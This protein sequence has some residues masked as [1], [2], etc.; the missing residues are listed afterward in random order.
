MVSS[1]LGSYFGTNEFS[2]QGPYGPSKLHSFLHRCRP[3]SSR[4]SQTPKPFFSPSQ[5]TFSPPYISLRPPYNPNLTILRD[6][7]K[8]T[9]L[10]LNLFSHPALLISNM[11]S[12]LSSPSNW[13]YSHS[14]AFPTFLVYKFLEMLAVFD[15]FVYTFGRFRL[16]RAEI[17]KSPFILPRW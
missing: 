8:P 14:T 15:F 5:L 2:V 6:K 16:L 3:F 4:P 1:C 11:T 9:F 10:Q 12:I 7:V 13:P 17:L